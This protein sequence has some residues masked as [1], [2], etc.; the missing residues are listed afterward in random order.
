MAIELP[1]AK[2]SVKAAVEELG[3]N[4]D[5]LSKWRGIFKNQGSVSQKIE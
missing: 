4:A 2:V 3:I 5:L 1:A